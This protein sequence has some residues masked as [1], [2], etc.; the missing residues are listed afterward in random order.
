MMS[1]LVLELIMYLKYNDHLWEIADVVEAYKRRKNESAEAKVCES[2]QKERFDKKK[3]KLYLWDN[4]MNALN[5]IGN[6]TT[7]YMDEGCDDDS[8]EAVA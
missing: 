6:V 8:M 3:D 4:V 1:P 2:I 7:G 5:D